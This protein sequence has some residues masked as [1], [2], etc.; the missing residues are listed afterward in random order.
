M[1]R[2]HLLARTTAQTAALHLP[3]RCAGTSTSPSPS[4]PSPPPSSACS[5]PEN[6]TEPLCP[7]IQP[8]LLDETESQTETLQTE[9]GSSS[10]GGAGQAFG[11][12][13]SHPSRQA[14]T[15][16]NRSA[17][18]QLSREGSVTTLHACVRAG[19][20]AAAAEPA[21]CHRCLPSLRQAAMAEMSQR[22]LTVWRA[23]AVR[24]AGGR[25]PAASCRGTACDSPSHLEDNPAGR[26]WLRSG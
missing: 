1:P 4:P 26:Q 7:V 21:A 22:S 17:K 6:R 14:D 25:R 16:H 23:A 13:A 8:P 11:A 24:P 9:A 5:A 18:P 19:Q 20:A 12:T 15:G 10:P 3:A 2:Q